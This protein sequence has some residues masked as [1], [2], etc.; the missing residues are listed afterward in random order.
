MALDKL[1]GLSGLNTLD[2]LG[3]GSGSG[4]AVNLSPEELLI[5]AKARGGATAD[6]A[7]ELSDPRRTFMGAVKEKV[8][9]AFKGFLDVLSTPSEIIA[10]VLSPNLT[11]QEAME[12]NT[13]VSDVL[14]GDTN[15]FNKDGDPTT[16]QKIGNFIVRLPVDILTDPLTYLSFGTA[17]GVLGLRS[18]GR[19]TLSEE[20]AKTIGKG[21]KAKREGGI[22]SGG[23]NQAGKETSKLVQS[24]EA[25]LKLIG[26]ESGLMSSVKLSKEGI[27]NIKNVSKN[28]DSI[29]SQRNIIKDNLKNLGITDDSIKFIEEFSEKELKDLLKKTVESPLDMNLAKKTLSNILDVRPELAKDIIDK[30]GIKYFGKTILSSQ[31]IASVASA[32]PGMTLLDNITYP[33]RQ[34]ILAPFDSNLVRLADD[35]TGLVRYQRVPEEFGNFKR[36]IKDN[37]ISQDTDLLQRLKNIQDTQKL[38]ELEWDTLGSSISIKKIPSDP[39]LAKAYQEIMGI[40]DEWS[41]VMKKSGVPLSVLDNYTGL[42]FMN[43]KVKR[44]MGSSTYAKADAIGS[45]MQAQNAKYIEQIG[46]NLYE[47]VPELKSIIGDV[48]QETT[49]GAVQKV[50]LKQPPKTP[51]DFS[52]DFVNKVQSVKSVPEVG[53]AIGEEK[54]RIIK[55]LTS[56]GMDIGDALKHPQVSKLDK[57]R[58]AVDNPNVNKGRTLIGKPETAIDTATKNPTKLVSEELEDGTYQF[59]DPEGKVFKRVAASASELEE[60]GIKGFDTNLMTSMAAIGMRNQRQALGQWF[61]EGMLRNFSKVAGDAGTD[62]W[63]AIDHAGLADKGLKLGIPLVDDSGRQLVFHPAIAKTFEDMMTSTLGDELTT[64][65]WKKFDKIQSYWKSSVTSIFPMFHGRNAISNVFLNIMDL[66]RHVFDPKYHTMSMDLIHKD[67]KLVGL[68]RDSLKAGDV[69]QKALAEINKINN[70]T[71]FTDAIG[72]NWTYGELRDVVKKYNIAF[73]KQLTGS[74]DIG[75][76]KEALIDMFGIGKTKTQQNLQKINPLS[77]QNV[78][79]SGG[80]ELGRVIEEQARLVNFV[81]NLRNTGD[82]GHAALRTKMFLFDYGNLTKFEK[83]VLRRLIPFYSFTRFNLEMQAKALTSVPGYVGAQLKAINSIGDLIGAENLTDEERKLLPSWMADSI[84][85]KRKTD[86]GTEVISGFGSPIE[87]PFQAFQPNMLLGGVS[88]LI[89]FPIEKLS[90]Y[91][92][93][94]GKPT[95]EVVDAS[96]YRLAPEAIKRFIGFSSYEGVTKDGKKYTVYTALRPENLHTLSNLPA[97][98]R[99]V[100]TLGNMTDEDLSTQVKSLQ[101]ITGIQARSIDFDLEEERQME[102][103]RKDLEK[104][105]KQ[106][107]VRGEFI[108]YYTKTNTKPI[109]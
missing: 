84:A 41:E 105:L 106:S 82:V 93:F 98:G 37:L 102:T 57:I 91:Q 47:S 32:I 96:D 3:G 44:F 34:S 12:Q 81:A 54:D 80:R 42:Y 109:E 17:Q 100:S 86:T 48:S 39:R 108:R 89:R 88:P 85:L 104:L 24:V 75:E 107:G 94:R 92:F 8:G 26:Q 21:L 35:E 52:D 29:K 9:N 36:Q 68:Y 33:L 65:F 73:N 50:V 45:A 11:I 19:V 60:A 18:A 5:I 7:S 56:E 74:A 62:S 51:L 101:S 87:Q 63:R 67:R 103:L 79:F 16:M 64:E 90:G 78:A 72:Y 28:L 71:V 15:I 59:T 4:G 61:M 76:G 53:F 43:P 99:V 83:N 38:T 27:E 31:R 49:E 77:Q 95:A 46:Q 70:T 30:G 23:L 22:I 97:V 69:G 25:E 66:G 2:G 40:S 55:Y 6:L 1:E 10:G 58:T 14:F 20:V 13:R